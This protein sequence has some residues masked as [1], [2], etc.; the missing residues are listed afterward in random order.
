MFLLQKIKNDFLHET[1]LSLVLLLVF[2]FLMMCFELDIVNREISDILFKRMG[3]N[4]VLYGDINSEDGHCD[5]ID[6]YKKINQ[7][8]LN[9]KCWTPTGGVLFY[10]I[11]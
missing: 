8:E 1:S 5:S 2:F 4:I 11:K 7:S 10:E 6:V 9:P 3:I